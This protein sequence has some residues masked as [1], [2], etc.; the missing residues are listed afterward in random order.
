[1]G[2]IPTIEF[3]EIEEE[4]LKNKKDFSFIVL[5]ESRF[6]NHKVTKKPI[7]KNFDRTIELNEFKIAK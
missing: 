6:A 4:D 3:K 1:M 2:K 7:V 5:D